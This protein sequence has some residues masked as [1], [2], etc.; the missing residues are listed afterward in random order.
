[1]NCG[2]ERAQARYENRLPPEPQSLGGFYIGDVFTVESAVP[3]CIG[4]GVVEGFDGGCIVGL[5]GG[6]KHVFYPEELRKVW[7]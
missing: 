7:G 5:C 6:K 1:M 3:G 2:F 4:R